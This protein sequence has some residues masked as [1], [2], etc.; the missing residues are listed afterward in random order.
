MTIIILFSVQVFAF[1]FSVRNPTFTP[2]F[3]CMGNG[4][5]L[6]QFLL[7]INPLSPARSAMGQQLDFMRLVRASGDLSHGYRQILQLQFLLLLYKLFE[8][9]NFRDF[10]GLSSSKG[11]F[12]YGFLLPLTNT[13]LLQLSLLWASSTPS[14]YCLSILFEL[15]DISFLLSSSVQLS[16]DYLFFLLLYSYIKRFRKQVGFKCVC[17]QPPLSKFQVFT[18]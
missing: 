13:S 10:L 5:F 16:I 15:V 3:Y 17:L 11:S 9:S 18:L 12:C 8:V 6:V 4:D 14:I 2:I 1:L 7:I